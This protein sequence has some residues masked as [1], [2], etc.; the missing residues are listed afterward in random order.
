MVSNFAKYGNSW[1]NTKKSGCH[2]K[3]MGTVEFSKNGFFL[4]KR[5]FIIVKIRYCSSYSENFFF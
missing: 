4:L 3:N 1:R 2:L 5:Y